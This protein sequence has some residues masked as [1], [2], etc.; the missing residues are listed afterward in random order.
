MKP[1]QTRTETA[2]R[3]AAERAVRAC[4]P[5]LVS[6]SRSMLDRERAIELD[7][8]RGSLMDLAKALE[9]GRK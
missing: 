3:L 7:E 1:L 8:A 6:L 2:L 5:V 4:A 9:D